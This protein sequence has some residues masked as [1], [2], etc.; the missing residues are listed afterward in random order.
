MASEE[1]PNFSKTT[2]NDALELLQHIETL[3][4]VPQRAKYPPLTLVEILASYMRIRQGKNEKLIDYLGRFK[5]ETEVVIRMFGKGLV[6]GFTHQTKAYQELREV[7]GSDPEARQQVKEMQKEM[8]EKHWERF[9]AIHFLRSANPTRFGDL[10]LD[11]KEGI[12]QQY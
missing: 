5:S 3:M 8:E 11:Y 7:S 6:M 4:H 10:L 2:K 1:M 12:R 9:K